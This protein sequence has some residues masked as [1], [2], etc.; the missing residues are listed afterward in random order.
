MSDKCKPETVS[1]VVVWP[2]ILLLGLA[3]QNLQVQEQTAL[4][5]E[6][7]ETYIYNIIVYMQYIIIYIRK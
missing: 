1:L 2:H 6:E 3:C 4:C 7:K 5:E